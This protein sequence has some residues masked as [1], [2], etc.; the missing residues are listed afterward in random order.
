VWATLSIVGGDQ[1]EAARGL[2]ERVERHAWQRLVGMCSYLL[3]RWTTARSHVLGQHPDTR[4][5]GGGKDRVTEADRELRRAHDD[6]W[7]RTADDQLRKM[8]ALLEARFVSGSDSAPPP[9]QQLVLVVPDATKQRAAG[10]RLPEG[11]SDALLLGG[12][13]QLEAMRA[14]MA[15]CVDA[16]SLV[17]QILQDAFACFEREARGGAGGGGAAERAACRADAVRPC[18]AAAAGRLV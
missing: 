18:T 6:A 2:G 9:E 16:R 14:V 10:R 1:V 13:Q 15:A 7:Q 5:G 17:A 11:A 8:R 12:G 4:G 3:H